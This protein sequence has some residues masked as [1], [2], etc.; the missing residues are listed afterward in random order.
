MRDI[1]DVSLFAANGDW[2]H[3]E[4]LCWSD[5]TQ[6]SG[7]AV[8]CSGAPSTWSGFGGTSVATPTFAGIQALINQKTGQSWGSGVL[9]NYYQIGQNEYGTAGGSFLGAGCNS[10]TGSG[11]GCA[12]NDVTQGDIDLACENNGTLEK[13]HCYMPT[14]THGVLQHGQRDRRD[15]SLR[16]QRLHLSSDLHHRRPEQ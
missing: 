1:P 5:P 12:F 13:A 14:G 6:T 10:S 2:G 11:A 4:T 3:F 9:N 7:G 16:R 8:S 15:R